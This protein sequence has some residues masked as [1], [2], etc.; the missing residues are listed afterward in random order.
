MTEIYACLISNEIQLTVCF[1]KVD[2]SDT[3]NP[4]TRNMKTA[5]SGQKSSRPRNSA[6]ER[7]S[8][9]PLVPFCTACN[10]L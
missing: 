5:I 1:F 8:T 7:L 9:L 2:N 3:F 4:L 6:L 10:A